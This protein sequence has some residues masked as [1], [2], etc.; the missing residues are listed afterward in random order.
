MTQDPNGPTEAVAEAMQT[1]FG[2]CVGDYPDMPLRD[3]MG[4]AFLDALRA[5]GY[6]VVK[7]YDPT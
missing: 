6:D 5:R 3:A 1:M 2:T 7:Q 4:A